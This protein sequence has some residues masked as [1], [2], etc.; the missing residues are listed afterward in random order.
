MNIDQK[1][2]RKKTKRA[3]CKQL[4]SQKY[5]FEPF[6]IDKLY[7]D[8]VLV[9]QIFKSYKKLDNKISNEMLQKI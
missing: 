2:R 7:S 9:N 3:L 5:Y 1:E 8:Y 4:L 6:T